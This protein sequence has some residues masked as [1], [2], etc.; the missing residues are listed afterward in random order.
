MT[1][2]YIHGEDI[3][4]QTCVLIVKQL[5]ELLSREDLVALKRAVGFVV[6]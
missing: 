5:Q 6:G 2:I 4:M 3:G 1:Y